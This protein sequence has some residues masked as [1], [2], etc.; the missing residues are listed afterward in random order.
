MQIP[1]IKAD[2][3][4]RYCGDKNFE[5][6]GQYYKNGSI[7]EARID[8]QTLKASCSGSRDTAYRVTAS[9][10]KSSIGKCCCTC[11]VGESGHCKHI[12]ALLLTWVYKPELFEQMPDIEK[13]LRGKDKK[14]LISLI[15]YLLQY[16]PDLELV[17]AARLT[18]DTDTAS[19]G[20]AA[21]YRQAQTVFERAVHQQASEL[22]LAD[23]LSAV[24]AV[25]DELLAAG[26]YSR[27]VAV[28]AGVADGVTDKLKIYQY[29]DEEGYVSEIVTEC[30][31]DLGICLEHETD[32]AAR[33]TAVMTLTAVYEADTDFFGGIGLSDE[34]P[35]IIIKLANDDEKRIVAA[36]L[37]KLLKKGDR[38]DYESWSYERHKDFLDSLS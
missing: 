6:G 11:P 26:D 7:F 33:N 35:E 34:V 9:F 16:D 8:K 19:S 12:A 28:F 25:G 37:D 27:A 36:K 13:A 5:R 4:R 32:L 23:K 3:I 14:K 30:V 2:D 17:L 31:E 24:T 20:S 29:F 22:D 10:G 1:K 15:G 38:S 18:A 21:Y